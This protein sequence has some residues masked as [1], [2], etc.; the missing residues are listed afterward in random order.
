MGEHGQQVAD[1]A[2]QLPIDFTG[3]SGIE[4]KPMRGFIKSTLT[5][6]IIFFLSGCIGLFITRATS[7]LTVS[8]SITV[9][10][11]AARAAAALKFTSLSKAI[12]L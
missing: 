8:C 11:T 7:V 5:V 4:D 6:G 12:I 9:I 3:T 2:E 10:C 1:G